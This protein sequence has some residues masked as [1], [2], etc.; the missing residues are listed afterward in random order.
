[1][2]EDLTLAN[3]MTFE[4]SKKKPVHGWF[5]YKEGYAPEIVERAISEDTGNILDP[6]CGVGTTLVCAKEK[7]IDSIGVDASPLAVFASRVKTDDYSK[8]DCEDA[9]SFLRKDTKGE[10]RWEFELFDPRAAFPKRNLNQITGLRMAIEKEEPKV[11][12]LLLLGLISI[13]PQAGLVVKDGGVLKI[14]KDKKALPA[15]EIFKR[16][17]KRMV[18]DI[19]NAPTGHC[20]EVYLG[21]ARAMDVPGNSVDLIVTSPPYLNNID[22]SKV[23]GLEL[24]LLEMS[25]ARAEEVRMRAIRSFIGKDMKVGEVPIE[26]RDAASRIPII[27]TY[28]RDME[29]AIKE[30]YR[31]LKDGREAHII[32]SNSVIHSTHVLVDEI[33]CDIG[34]RIGFRESDIIVGAKRVADVRPQKIETRESIVILRK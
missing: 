29:E 20:P 17:I 19:E 12:N 22:Y 4:L 34:E 21:D 1:M 24:S 7:R 26:V 11:R 28:F 15:K 6:F 27:G 5:W 14:K 32:V 10:F 2:I 33:F 18:K 31:T 25:K 9:L 23:Y 30:M 8:K 16:K 13:L 3:Q